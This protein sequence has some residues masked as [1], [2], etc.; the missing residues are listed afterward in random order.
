MVFINLKVKVFCNYEAKRND[1]PFLNKNMTSKFLNVL[2]FE[3]ASVKRTRGNNKLKPIR[4][5]F[6]LWSQGS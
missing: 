1:H 4:D 2:H 5:I 3:D 6:K